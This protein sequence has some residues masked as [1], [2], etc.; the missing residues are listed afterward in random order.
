M[1]FWSDI[2]YCAHTHTHQ[3]HSIITLGAN[4]LPS[5]SDMIFER[6]QNGRAKN[7]RDSWR[8]HRRLPQDSPCADPFS[9]ITNNT[10]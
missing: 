5:V 6:S 9:Q 1:S 7:T 4:P 10:R 2:T 8:S 3:Y